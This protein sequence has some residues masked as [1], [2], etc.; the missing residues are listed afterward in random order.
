M[1]LN[2]HWQFGD[3]LLLSSNN[4]ISSFY[5][6]RGSKHCFLTSFSN[7]NCYFLFLVFSQNRYLRV[8]LHLSRLHGNPIPHPIF[9]TF[10]SPSTTLYMRP[11]ISGTHDMFSQSKILVG[12]WYKN[13][14][15]FF[16]RSAFCRRFL[17]QTSI[18]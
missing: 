11:H 9:F 7:L 3:I 6:I 12:T 10:G 18:G 15:D 2:E 4:R 16:S 13:V 5:W 14:L 8:S 1:L 17:M